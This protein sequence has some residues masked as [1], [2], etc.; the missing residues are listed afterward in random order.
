MRACT[1]WD[2]GMIL[3]GYDFYILSVHKNVFRSNVT[4]Y[5]SFLRLSPT[6]VA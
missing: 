1:M 3:A 5:Q 6:I 4:F 2:A